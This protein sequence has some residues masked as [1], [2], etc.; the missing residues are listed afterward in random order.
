[1]SGFMGKIWSFSKRKL[2]SLFKSKSITTP[3]FIGLLNG[4]LPCGLVY[5]AL[6]AAVSMGGS[7]ESAIYMGFFGI[8][9]APLLIVLAVFG[10]IVSPAIRNKFN[11]VVPYFLVIVAVLII[12]RGLN[13][14]I[15]FI[16]PKMEDSG[17]MQHLHSKFESPYL[18]NLL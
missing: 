7:I 2:A 18:E 3:F 15:P 5:A 12:L 13:L 10:N 17:K 1:M 9:T 11:K 8:G 16:S 14:G 6:F 4:L